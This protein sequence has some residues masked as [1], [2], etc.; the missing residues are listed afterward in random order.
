MTVGLAQ[1]ANVFPGLGRRLQSLAGSQLDTSA[2]VL[3]DA[4]NAA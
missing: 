2:S 3:L 1:T 4:G